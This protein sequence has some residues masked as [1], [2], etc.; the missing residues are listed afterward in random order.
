MENV[1]VFYGHL[2]YFT[3][4]WYNFRPFGICS[5]WLF[6][7]FLRFDTYVWTKKNLATL[8]SS[9]HVFYRY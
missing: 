4:I 3:A 9:A 6:G 8:K 2:E 7:T 1:V 5:L